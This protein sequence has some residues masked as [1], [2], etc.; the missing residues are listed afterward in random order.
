M[1]TLT[2][3]EQL[4]LRHLQLLKALSDAQVTVE[5]GDAGWKVGVNYLKPGTRLGIALIDGEWVTTAHVPRAAADMQARVP[6]YE[7]LRYGSVRPAIPA[8]PP[9]GVR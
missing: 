2:K 4:K 3:Y 9:P 1:T 8:N 5:H 7:P 6:S